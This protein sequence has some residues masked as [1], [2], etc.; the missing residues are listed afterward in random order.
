MDEARVDA[1]VYPSWLLPPAHI[2]R[3]REEYGGDNSQRV[4]PATG[5]P[6]ITVPMGF[7][8]GRYPAGLQI[9]SRP[10]TEGLLFKLAFAYEQGTRWRR[11][12]DGFPPLGVEGGQE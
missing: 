6:A 11:P 9:L 1:L 12:P 5:M 8:Y 4:A 3:A 10:Y 7:S 2:D